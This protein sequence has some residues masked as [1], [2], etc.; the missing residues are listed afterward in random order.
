MRLQ[1]AKRSTQQLIMCNSRYD[2]FLH[3]SCLRIP[4]LA[5]GM[6]PKSHSYVL[7]S[8]AMWLKGADFKK[9]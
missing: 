8:E 9:R 7:P 5:Y 6:A 1:D 2:V 4:D 3:H